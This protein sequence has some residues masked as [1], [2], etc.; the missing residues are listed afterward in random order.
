MDLEGRLLWG[1]DPD[2]KLYRPIAVDEEGRQLFTAGDS[3][4]DL[5]D[6]PSSYS[7]QG[8]K[9][10]AVHSGESALEFI[11][12]G[13]SGWELLADEDLSSPA[14]SVSWTGLDLDAARIYDIYLAISEGASG[15]TTYSIYFNNDTT[16]ANY[17]CRKLQAKWSGS[18]EQVLTARYNAAYLFALDPGKT[19]VISLG[20]MRETG[21][22]YPYWLVKSG[23]RQSTTRTDGVDILYFAGV[24]PAAGNVTRIDI[25]ASNA[26][27]IGAGS[28]L[29][30]FTVA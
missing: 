5:P 15:S 23:F 9:V 10:V 18:A 21:T 20:V 7:G 6:T 14:T 26:D 13:S 27:G 11:E 4:L 30:L 29:R 24:S 28:K 19:G 16:A 8:G 17:W 2:A 22:G 12:A 1:Y 25:T 3:F